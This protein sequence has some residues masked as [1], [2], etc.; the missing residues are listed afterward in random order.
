MHSPT[1]SPSKSPVW[2]EE[3]ASLLVKG[4]LAAGLELAT[5]AMQNSLSLKQL[6]ELET[7]GRSAFYTESI[8]YATGVKLLRKLGVPFEH[9]TTAD[10]LLTADAAGA[11]Q[12][13]PN[14]GQPIRAA[15]EPVAAMNSFGKSILG[16]WRI[17]ALLALLMGMAYLLFPIKQARTTQQDLAAVEPN[18]V[19]PAPHLETSA[20]TLTLA[21]SEPAAISPLTTGTLPKDASDKSIRNDLCAFTGRGIE[22]VS[23]YP[24]KPADYVYVKATQKTQICV[25][26]AT[27]KTTS[28]TL[29]TN[30]SQNVSGASP[31]QFAVERP[32]DVKIY[33]Q[34]QRV[35]AQ[36]DADFLVLK[37]V[38]FKSNRVE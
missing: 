35:H 17:F 32:D 7:G 34:G 3:H 38:P 18:E 16:A 21:A 26:D 15:S 25:R 11:E 2:S 9:L 36:S 28:Q 10:E 20:A 19:K 33:F 22:V 1:P 14:Q 8:K 29:N 23:S 24:T 12:M 13:A 27:G 31:F 30:E 37:G 5:L 4:R 6:H